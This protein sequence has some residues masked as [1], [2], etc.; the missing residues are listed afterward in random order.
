M[1]SRTMTDFTPEEV[2]QVV[3]DGR[4]CRGANLQDID[5]VKA[6]LVKANFAEAN[7]SGADLSEAYL[8]GANLQGANLKGAGYNA[9]TKWPD[10]GFNPVAAGAVL[11]DDMRKDEQD[12]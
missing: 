7:L 3:L 5:L 8:S 12:G 10:E 2:I 9:D 6:D 1:Y 11:V 4:K